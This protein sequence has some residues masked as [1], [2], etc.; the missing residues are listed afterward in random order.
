M[1]ICFIKVCIEYIQVIPFL[2]TTIA[3]KLTHYICIGCIVHVAWGGLWY[4]CAHEYP[5]KCFHHSNRWSHDHLKTVNNHAWKSTLINGMQL[6][7][8]CIQCIGKGKILRAFKSKLICYWRQ[9]WTALTL[10]SLSQ[11]LASAR[12]GSNAPRA[13]QGKLLTNL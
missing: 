3:L 11:Q 7:H 10:C 4:V 8:L 1:L 5:A 2:P 6:P 13:R 9:Y 12:F